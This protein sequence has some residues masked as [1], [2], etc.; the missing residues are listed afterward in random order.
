[1]NSAEHFYETKIIEYINSRNGLNN[2]QTEIKFRS[3]YFL[4]AEYYFF[5]SC[6][7]VIIELQ[8]N[9]QFSEFNTFADKKTIISSSLLFRQRYPL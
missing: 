8:T 9:L 6:Y 2:Y 3:Y 7:S 5:I 1:M 4:L